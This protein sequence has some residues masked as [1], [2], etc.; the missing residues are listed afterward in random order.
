MSLASELKEKF[1]LIIDELMNRAQTELKDTLY[2]Q[3]NAQ[4]ILR[5]RY[6]NVLEVIVEYLET[7]SES[8]FLQH[9]ILI[10]MER[11]Y[12]GIDDDNPMTVG[13]IEQRR[14]QIV[15]SVNLYLRVVKEFTFEEHHEQ[16]EQIWLVVRRF[17]HQIGDYVSRRIN[18]F[19]TQMP[20]LKIQDIEYEEGSKFDIDPEMWP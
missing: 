20:T 10:F 3:M 6:T 19:A 4:K 17:I 9:H 18:R 15:T 14:V 7:S 2:A 11:Y 13:I 1:N 16:L 12:V 5:A 8:L